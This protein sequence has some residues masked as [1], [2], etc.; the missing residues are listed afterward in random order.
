M[1]ILASWCIFDVDRP[2][3]AANSIA[4]IIIHNL[5]V[6]KSLLRSF[7]AHGTQHFCRKIKESLLHAVRWEVDVDDDV[8]SSS[9]VTMSGGYLD[10][11]TRG[12]Q[13][14]DNE[15]GHILGGGIAKRS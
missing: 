13:Y 4:Q 9:A 3:I 14:L 1:R 10:F 12:G 11:V 5:P 15:I 7:L 2:D 6:G 8:F